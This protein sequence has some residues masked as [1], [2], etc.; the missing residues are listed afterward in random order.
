V[1]R[2]EPCALCLAPSQLQNSHIIPEFLYDPMYDAIHRFHVYSVEGKVERRL[3]Q[4]GLREPML[5][6]NCETQIGVYE[7]YVS[8]LLRG[9]TAASSNTFNNLV[10]VSP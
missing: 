4:Q 6:K 1:T 10:V 7:R 9:D 2:L 5:C 3:A 8:L